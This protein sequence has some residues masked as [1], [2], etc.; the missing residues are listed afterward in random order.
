MTMT[1][2]MLIFAFVLVGTLALSQVF[3][4]EITLGPDGLPDKSSQERINAQLTE[5]VE[6]IY[7][8][9][10]GKRDKYTIRIEC[11]A[12]GMVEGIG[13]IVRTNFERKNYEWV[14]I[15]VGV[16]EDQLPT[17]KSKAPKIQINGESMAYLHYLDAESYMSEEKYSVAETAYTKSLSYKEQGYPHLALGRLCF[18]RRDVITGKKHMALALK[19]DKSLQP[20]VD[21]AISVMKLNGLM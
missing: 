16:I 8:E 5:R 6:K 20:D 14:H 12:N 17:F 9:E 15:N 19:L 18:A 2:K 13:A 1:T 4:Q 11:M 3:A 21:K 10:G 7:A